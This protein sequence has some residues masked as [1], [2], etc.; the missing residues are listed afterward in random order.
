MSWCV[1]SFFFLLSSVIFL[2]YFPFHFNF[3]FISSQPL[4]L[5]FPTSFFSFQH[6]TSNSQFQ[7]GLEFVTKATTIDDPFFK[8][9]LP[10]SSP[11]A[12]SDPQLQPQSDGIQ[13]MSVDILPTQLPLDASRHFSQALMPYL[14]ALVRDYQGAGVSQGASAGAGADGDGPLVDALDRATIARGGKLMPNHEWLYA[15][16]DKLDKVGKALD[17]PGSSSTSA[18]SSGPS[19]RVVGVTEKDTKMETKVENKEKVGKVG[20]VRKEGTREMEKRKTVLLFG[21]GMVARPAVEEF[22]KR[23]D[24]NLVVGQ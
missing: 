19:A 23:P 21:S 9:K 3:I 12:H 7:G 17:S 22:L 14:R 24:I 6:T 8:S 5:P 18:S 16:L 13:V 2:I 15:S 1:F 20:K 10:T 4:F 11:D